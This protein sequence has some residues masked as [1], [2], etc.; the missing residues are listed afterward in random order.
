[1]RITKSL[2]VFIVASGLSTLFAENWPQWRGPSADGISQETGIPTRW[3]ATENIAWKA[4]L[5]G[6]GTS[7]PIVWGQLVFLT[8]QI[9]D[10]PYA[11]GGRD[12]PDAVTARKTGQR[13]SVEFAVLA[14]DRSTGELAWKYQFPAEGSLTPVHSKHNLASP[15]CVTDG[16]RVYA[17]FGT[18]QFVALGMNGELV[19]ERNLSKDY[20][21]FDIRWGHGSSPAL[22]DESVILLCDHLPASYMV[23]LDKKTGK[24]LWK[25]DR[26]DGMRSYTTPFVVRSGGRDELIVNSNTEIAAFDPS[27]GDKLWRVAERVRVP[28]PMPVFADGMIYTSRGYTSG[29]Y[30]AIRP[31]GSGD[32]S[33]S[34]V[35]WH[36]PTGAPYVASILHHDGL[37][38]MATERGIARCVDAESGETVWT[39]RLGGVFSASPVVAD[40]KIYFANEDGV[41][42]VIEAAREFKLVARNDLSERILASPAISNGQ[43]FLRS[44]NHL[45]CIGKTPGAS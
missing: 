13:D 25:A 17:W 12:F 4:P 20:A 14:F 27:D 24:Q 28:V 18:G 29:P 37:L 8:T 6:L 38:Y 41:T 7:T 39:E 10:G 2:F 5:P 30:M 33:D 3:S 16:Q 23:A 11:D 45:F 32:V 1:M 22:Y 44:D 35:Q 9:G 40:G 42:F 15:S 31:G 36:V 34:H 21:P 43:I 19:W 26:P